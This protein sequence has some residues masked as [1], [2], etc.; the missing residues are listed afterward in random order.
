MNTITNSH[1]EAAGFVERRRFKPTGSWIVTYRAPE[2]G[3]DV[4]GQRYAVVCD[5]HSTLVGAD[6]RSQARADMA[7]PEFCEDCMRVAE[8]EENAS[9]R[10]ALS[11]AEAHRE[12]DHG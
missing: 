1:R 3:I 10:N 11:A 2:Q 4:C 7:W 9:E 5:S 8:R 6:T 12:V